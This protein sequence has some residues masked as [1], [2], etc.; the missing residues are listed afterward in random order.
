MLA[1]ISR[2]GKND[3]LF[4]LVSKPFR[5]TTKE[6]IKHWAHER[7]VSL[8]PL[9]CSRE[10]PTERTHDPTGLP[11][12]TNDMSTP[13]NRV[14]FRIEFKDLEANVVVQKGI[15]ARAAISAGTSESDV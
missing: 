12:A 15:N 5:P 4:S 7:E 6:E 9:P 2:H 3:C 10:E 8:L 13:K 11:E 1:Y 14:P